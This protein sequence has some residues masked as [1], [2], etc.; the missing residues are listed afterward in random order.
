MSESWTNSTID[1]ER[2]PQLSSIAFT[3]LPLK[4]VWLS[5]FS[6]LFSASVIGVVGTVANTLFFHWPLSLTIYAYL[7]L[8]LLT[9]VSL[10]LAPLAHRK[11][12][13]CLREHDIVYQHGLFYQK[14]LF[15]P[16]NRIQHIE[17]ER[18]PLQRQMGLSTI[19]FFSAGGASAD[20]QIAG[21]TQE[22]AE[23][24]R[25]LV[26]ERTRLDDGELLEEISK[27]E[28]RDQ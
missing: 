6:T 2:V 24:L 7:T 12:G 28:S 22:N 27:A 10:I 14:T 3:P 4:A 11:K 19:K 13:V 5:I 20:L 8:G 18:G 23:S 17:T 9:V 1:L 16:I 26:L 21:L 25:Q 15:L